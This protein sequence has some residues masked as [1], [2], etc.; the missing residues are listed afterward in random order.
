M[1]DFLERECQEWRIS[2]A[3]SPVAWDERLIIGGG[4][5]SDAAGRSV[6]T[7]PRVLLVGLSHD[8]D[9]AHLATRIS[10]QGALVE[11]LLVDRIAHQPAAFHPARECAREYD[12][13]YCRAIRPSDGIHFH[14]DRTVRRSADWTAVDA[15]L[16]RHAAAQAETLLWHWLH[17]T[18]VARW[19]NSPS[20]LRAAENKLIQ[21]T[22]AERVGLTV[23][24]TLTTTS[25]SELRGFETASPFGVVHKS[26][27]SPVVT[28]DQDGAAF[29]YT[30]PIEV[31]EICDIGFPCLFQH[32]LIPRAEIR[33]TVVGQRIF[34]ASLPRWNDHTPD[35]RRRADDH[36]GFAHHQLP[37]ELTH[38]IRKLMRILDIE[39]GAVDLIKTDDD[40]YF[41]EI[42]PSA[43]LMWLEQTLGMR[44]CETVANLILCTAQRRPS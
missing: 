35:W 38:R 22:E 25:L 9:L 34:S 4:F 42:N 18:T 30:T 8:P 32:R 40:T 29:L 3:P 15:C 7:K 6:S 26:L 11:V 39:I 1:Q 37:E 23:P 19:I 12:I 36:S 31:G 43:A 24:P 20:S 27:T 41:L 16:A 28:T 44:L 17:Q 5:D 33:T 21:L 14:Y 2:E 10:E 13:G